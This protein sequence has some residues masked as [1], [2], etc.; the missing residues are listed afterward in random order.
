MATTTHAAQ[1]YSG[2]KF[3]ISRKNG[4]TDKNGEPYFFEYIKD[5]PA[6]PGKRLFETRGE[7]SYELFKAI[8]GQLVGIA[9]ENT[10]FGDK[11]EKHLIIY[12]TDGGEDYRL[13][14]GK[15]EERYGM[16]F[17]KRILHKNFDPAQTLSLSP[18][19]ITDKDGRTNMGVSVFS[20]PNKLTGTKDDA[21]LQGIAQPDKFYNP[22][23]EKDEYSWKPVALWLWNQV[24]AFVIPAL[25][26]DPISAPKAKP[27]PEPT[28]HMAEAKKVM[29]AAGF[30]EDPTFPTVNVTYHNEVGSDDLPF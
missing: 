2:R 12:L 18:F 16:D 13:Q 25:V 1:T 29:A 4:V 8:S 15:P 28:A 17:L 24:S 30:V 5:M 20:G 23:T 11:V 14:L 22:K 6:D 10:T 19:A 7:N 3:H 21:H 26:K 9:I 27:L